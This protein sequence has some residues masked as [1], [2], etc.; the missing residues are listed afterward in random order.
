MLTWIGEE[1][2][3]KNIDQKISTFKLIDRDFIMEA[4][5]SAKHSI[6]TERECSRALQ[7]QERH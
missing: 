7:N 5:F 4:V 1:N 3:L 2:I 6:S